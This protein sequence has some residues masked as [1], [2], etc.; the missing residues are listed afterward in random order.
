MEKKQVELLAPAG[1]PEGFYGAVHAG[2]DAVYLGGSRYGARAYAENFTEQELIRCIR[3]GHIRGVKIYMTVN[4]LLK[5]DESSQLY[6]YLAPF[7][8]AGL[9]AVI[10]QDFGALRLIKRQFP[11][12]SLHAST[13]MTLCSRYGAELLRGM[14]VS[15][16]VPA[17]ELSLKELISIR[18][19]VDVELETFIHGAMCYSYSGQCLFSSILGGRSG[20]RGRCAQPC[21]LPYSILAD[22]VC[23]PEMYPLSLKDMCTIDHIPELIEAGIDSFK[24]E[25]RMK[26]P[27]YAAGVTAIYRK[28]MDWY[29]EKKEKYGP[30]EAVARYGVEAGDERQLKSLYIRTQTQ[31]GYYYRHNGKE[32]VTLSS[33]GYSGTDEVLLETIRNQ[34]PLEPQKLPVQIRASFTEGLPASV[35]MGRGQHWVCAEGETVTA[36]QKTPVTVENIKKQLGKLGDSCFYP[37]EIQVQAGNHIF[38][39]LKQINELR[40]QAV[41]KLEAVESRHSK[42]WEAAETTKSAAHSKNAG[43]TEETEIT[44]AAERKRVTKIPSVQYDAVSQG[45]AVS[46][47]TLEQLKQLTAWTQEHKHAPGRVYVE[48]DLMIQS[49]E[50]MTPL[51]RKLASHSVLYAALPHILRE[52]DEVYLNKLYELADEKS[53]IQGILIRSADG[54]G[55]LKSRK[56]KCRWRADAGFYIWNRESAAGFSPELEGFCL[57]WELNAAEQRRLLDMHSGGESMDFESI[58]FE[59]LVYGRTPMMITANC[60]LRT[61]GR[62]QKNSTLETDL[63]DRYRKVFPVVRNC[64]HCMNIIY[65]SV[66]LSLHRDLEKW[67]RYV[68]LRMDFTVERAAETASVLDAFLLNMSWKDTGH[69]TGHE[70]RGVE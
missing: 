47:R 66:P 31:N 67:K 21:R 41:E 51:F 70:K 17:R 2:A 62:C 38:Y 44:K 53:L 7:Y 12:L 42:G 56:K 33:P 11:N 10:V 5:E 24:I 27:E 16:I 39:P 58:D 68:C 6:D 49:R 45:F 32:M 26:R 29:L 15:R 20:N 52:T 61:Q 48:G 40:R 57:P 59:K 30:E 60:V 28:Y 36:A 18:R 14:G 9:D 46:V 1:S 3:Y 8:E 25:G 55:F 63:L 37:E 43:E 50:D 64:A 22:G 13:Q 4:T 35:A 54:L 23:S 19:Q 34:Y 69:T 65:N